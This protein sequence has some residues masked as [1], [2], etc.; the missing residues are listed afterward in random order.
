MGYA[1]FD[2]ERVKGPERTNPEF[3]SFDSLSETINHMA[4]T[5]DGRKPDAS[6]P[7]LAERFSSAYPQ[8]ADVSNL[9]MGYS[10]FDRGRV[11]GPEQ[12]NPEFDSL[13]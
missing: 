12:P 13:R 3:D 6:R 7:E 1:R 10:K 2:R 9:G 4:A 5:Q 8:A 11:E